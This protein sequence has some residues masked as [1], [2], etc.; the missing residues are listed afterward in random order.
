MPLIVDPKDHPLRVIRNDCRVEERILL[1]DRN[2][3]IALRPPL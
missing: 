2:N 1:G 3:E